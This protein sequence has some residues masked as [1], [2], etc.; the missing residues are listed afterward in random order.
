MDN[1]QQVANTIEESKG[2]QAFMASLSEP[3][4]TA[5]NQNMNMSLG[6]KLSG[7]DMFT[8]W[9][10][11]MQ[12]L[13][14]AYG[15]A[16]YVD[17][18]KSAETTDP[19][20][21]ARTMLAI[22][23]NVDLNQLTLIKGFANDPAGAW[24]ALSAEYA[25]KSNQDM[26]T[27]LIEL[28]GMRLQ[29]NASVKEAKKHFEA[30]IDLNLRL[31]EIDEKRALSDLVIGVLMCMSLPNDMEQ[32]RYRRLSGTAEELTAKNVR[33]DVISLLRR[34]AIADANADDDAG[35]A[36]NA[37]RSQRFAF[38]GKCFNCGK[39]GHRAASCRSKNR[40]N[41]NGGGANLALL[42][43]AFSSGSAAP[44]KGLRDWVLDGATTCGHISTC[45]EHFKADLKLFDKD[46]R[47]TIGGVG[48][49]RIEVHAKGD[50]LLKLASGR[51]VT[52]KD[53]SYAPDAVA[54]L[55]G[56]RAALSKLGSGAEH[57]ETARASK[58]VGPDGKV[59]MTSS[60]RQGLLYVDLASGQDFC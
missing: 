52:L 30:M 9:M 37:N 46:K 17:K 14:S 5:S 34:M 20:K 32:V 25:G 44:R 28:F 27:L 24:A 18:T 10:F 26:A 35:Q 58:I 60:L 53:V 22:T 6:F 19:V 49:E 12:T 47:P 3:T 11:A 1:A 45:R 13:L 51:S 15:L 38:Q 43:V 39:V 40:S 16:D 33:D 31:K 59:I 29:C 4:E 42:S 23:R 48:G 57:R 8:T 21:K 54:N 56:V 2:S 50:V 41:N 7:K 36:M 55:F